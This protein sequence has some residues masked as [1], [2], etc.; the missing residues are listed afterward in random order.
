MAQTTNSAMAWA[1]IPEAVVTL[2]SLPRIPE[3]KRC[4]APALTSWTH[5]SLVASSRGPGSCQQQRISAS[6]SCSR[7]FWGSVSLTTSRPGTIALRVSRSLS[8]NL[9]G[10]E[11]SHQPF[12]SL[13]S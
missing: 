12:F 6:W 9:G 11:Q 8:W 3:S 5:L 4:S 2:I 13:Q 10:G 7:A 1:W